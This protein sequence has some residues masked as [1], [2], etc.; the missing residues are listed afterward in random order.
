MTISQGDEAVL[1]ERVGHVAIIT[2]NRPEALN[3][4]NARLSTALGEALQECSLDTDVRAIVIAGAGRAF[5]AGH[6]L[7]AIAEGEDVLDSHHPD[8]GYAGIVRH[9][10][11]KPIIAAAHGYMLGGG[12]EIGLSCDLIVAASTLLL[13][14]P[15][16]TMGL[17]AAAG[18]VPRIA[19]QLP[20]RIAARLAY[21]GEFMSADEALLWGLVNEVVAEEH[22]VERAVDLGARIA[23]NAPRGVQASKR[24]IRALE[25][26]S[27]WTEP[28][29][30][31]LYAELAAIRATADASEGPRAFIEKR[32]PHWSGT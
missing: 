16:V 23:R 10:I 15:E 19:Q 20:L 24:V 32:Q 5:C 17:F 11:D 25:T 9:R 21:T 7:K 27:T 4:I 8:W 12:L 2:L 6:D 18:G 26:E 22:V 3:T 28:A 1:L 29:W 14:L 13:G 30:S 31:M